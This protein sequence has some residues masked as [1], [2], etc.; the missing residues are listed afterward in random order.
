M[1]AELYKGHVR[2]AV[3]GIFRNKDKILVAQGYD[4]VKKE[5]FCRPLGGGI[6]FEEKGTE[7][8]KREITE[9][10]K[11]Q[12]KNIEYLNIIENI[13]TWEGI[14]GHELILVYEAKFEDESVYNKEYFDIYDIHDESVKERNFISNWLKRNSTY[15]NIQ[16]YHLTYLLPLLTN[17]YL[18]YLQK[19][20]Q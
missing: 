20:M 4:S 12:V 8:L 2:P 18:C 5:V 19:T 6:K 14:P 17:C 15:L 11:L 9:E 13:F 3:M 7:A 16:Q 10:L 1:K